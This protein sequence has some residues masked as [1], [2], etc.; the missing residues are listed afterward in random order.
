MMISD[1]ASVVTKLFAKWPA[2][3]APRETGETRNRFITPRS[4]SLMT[5]MPDQPLLNIAFITTMPG[6]KNSM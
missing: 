3:I 1:C 4:R 6:V 2:M 5:D